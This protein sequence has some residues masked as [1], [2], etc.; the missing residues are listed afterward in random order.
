MRY[1]KKFKLDC[2][3]KYKA[4]EHIDDPGGCKH[5]TFR[6]KVR[7]WVRIYDVLGEIGLEHKKPKRSWKDKL[8]MIQRVLGGESLTEVA[9]SNGTQSYN[10]SNWYKIYE[11]FGVDGLK[12][13]RRGRPPKMTKKPKLSNEPKTKE[14][15]EKEL[16]YLRA[17]NEYLKKLKALVQKRKDRQPKKK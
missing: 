14:E 11:K 4:G 10:L 5:E 6:K 8:D 15:F 12:L 16:E 13:D 3:K 1:T 2:I 17:E 9:L 7:I